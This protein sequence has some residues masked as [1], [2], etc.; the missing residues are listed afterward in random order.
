MWVALIVGASMFVLSLSMN[1]TL[2]ARILRTKNRDREITKTSAVEQLSLKQILIIATTRL[3]RMLLTE[4]LV[5]YLSIYTAFRFAMLF[6]FFG[7]YPLVYMEV[8]SFD[9]KN[10]GLAFIGILVGFIF[11]V[12]TFA[13]LDKTVYRRAMRASVG[14]VVPKHRLYASMIGSIM[15]PISLFW[16]V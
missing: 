6:S 12:T 8:Y 10:T 11:A 7:S 1:E 2:K 4:P 15:L 3:V 13:V 5:F 14:R 16:S 9:M